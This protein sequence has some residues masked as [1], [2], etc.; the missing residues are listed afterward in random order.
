MSG[1][2]LRISSVNKVGC[3]D[4]NFHIQSLSRSKAGACEAGKAE[5]R[6]LGVS[7]LHRDAAEYTQRLLRQ[8]H[9]MLPFKY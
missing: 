8:P 4:H 7:N 1:I 6:D 9:R 3:L 2:I 5:P